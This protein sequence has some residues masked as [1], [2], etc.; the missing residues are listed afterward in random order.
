M[1]KLF[2]KSSDK[3]TYSSFLIINREFVELYKMLLAFLVFANIIQRASGE[4]CFEINNH[5]YS[6]DCINS[7]KTI[8][9][10]LYRQCGA[11]KD[12]G[13]DCARYFIDT[14]E[15][16]SGVFGGSACTLSY[17]NI[18]LPDACAV[19][20]TRT[21][22][23]NGYGTIEDIFATIGI[24]L[25]GLVTL[26]LLTSFV[27]HCFRSSVN[28]V[29]LELGNQGENEERE[30]INQATRPYGTINGNERQSSSLP[31]KKS[32]EVDGD[33]DEEGNLKL[34]SQK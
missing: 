2:S 8:V 6:L 5:D 20:V 17:H 27:I 30:A 3:K 25:G 11:Y 15:F 29:Q 34:V 10:E 16:C 13:D 32:E 26:C 1:V 21:Y 9:A 31:G 4:T 23:R 28:E 22:C 33:D 24:V 12:I 7:D 18:N 14:L 19:N